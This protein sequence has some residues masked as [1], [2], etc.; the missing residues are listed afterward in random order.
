MQIKNTMN[1]TFYLSD[2]QVANYEHTVSAK[3]WGISPNM[4]CWRECKLVPLLQTA[5][6]QYLSK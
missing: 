5:T 4:P 1:T 2:W 3:L 6:W